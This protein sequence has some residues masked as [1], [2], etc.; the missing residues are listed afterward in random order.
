MHEVFFLESC[1]SPRGVLFVDVCF[2]APV[3]PHQ[4]VLINMLICFSHRFRQES[5]ADSKLL[6]T[7]PD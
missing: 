4:T 5:K 6:K 1:T 2:P 3:A 7:V